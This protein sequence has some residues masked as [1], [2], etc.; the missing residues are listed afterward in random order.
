M[1]AIYE[2]ASGDL[3]TGTAARIVPDESAGDRRQEGKRV[4]S[5]ITFHDQDGLLSDHVCHAD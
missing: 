1:S 2:D 3:W 5:R 4:P